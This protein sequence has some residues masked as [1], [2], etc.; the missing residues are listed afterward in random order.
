MDSPAQVLANQSKFPL[1]SVSTDEEEENVTNIV[2][3]HFPEKNS[4]CDR[5]ETLR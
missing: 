4:A 3:L 1:D 5:N 2:S